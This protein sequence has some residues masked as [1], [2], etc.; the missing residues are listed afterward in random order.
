MTDPE[1]SD[2]FSNRGVAAEVRSEL[3]RE[4]SAVAIARRRV[5]HAYP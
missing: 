5:R 2:G 4:M 3:A 1:N